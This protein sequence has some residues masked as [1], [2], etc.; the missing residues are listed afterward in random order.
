MRSSDTKPTN[1]SRF[2][3]QD[4][5]FVVNGQWW[6]TTREG[7]QGPYDSREAAA[8][9]VHRYADMMDT[10]DQQEMEMEIAITNVQGSVSE[11]TP[12]KS[13]EKSSSSATTP[14]GNGRL[15]DSL[16]RD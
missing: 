6:F 4:R 8:Q 9:D 10:T 5:V 3:E 16:F 7:E 2:R 14:R 1:K 15:L 12:P 11:P 13:A